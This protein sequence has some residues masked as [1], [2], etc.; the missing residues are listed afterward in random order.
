MKKKQE[1]SIDLNEHLN[2]RV[3]LKRIIY[4]IGIIAS[5]W[6]TYVLNRV[7]GY[8]LVMGL[9]SAPLFFAQFLAAFIREFFI[10]LY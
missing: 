8:L 1:K 10:I 3:I 6:V 5:L 9:T 7:G 2:R 4:A